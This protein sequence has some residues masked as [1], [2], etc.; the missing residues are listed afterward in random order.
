MLGLTFDE[1][2]L[3]WESYLHGVEAHIPSVID[4]VPRNGEQSC[5][6]CVDAGDD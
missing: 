2:E 5:G 6:G 1:T 3:A 4:M